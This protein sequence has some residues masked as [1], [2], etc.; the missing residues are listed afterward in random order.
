MNKWIQCRVGGEGVR[1]SIVY[2][3]YRLDLYYM[4]LLYYMNDT[5]PHA[6]LLLSTKVTHPEVDDRIPSV[7]SPSARPRRLANRK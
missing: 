7:I 4:I 5:G 3:L 1:A 2:F 6:E